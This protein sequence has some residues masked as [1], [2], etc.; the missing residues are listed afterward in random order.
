[1]SVMLKIHD[2]PIKNPMEGVSFHATEDLIDRVWWD[3][4]VLEVVTTT[5]EVW[6]LD[7]TEGQWEMV[8]Q[9]GQP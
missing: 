5:G 8:Q 4:E 7:F 3:G 9:M 6:R 2:L 1:M